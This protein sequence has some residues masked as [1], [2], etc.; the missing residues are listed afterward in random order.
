VYTIDKQVYSLKRTDKL[1][2]KRNTEHYV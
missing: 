1:L 2:F